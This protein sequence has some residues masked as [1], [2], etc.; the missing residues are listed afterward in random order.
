MRATVTD[1]GRLIAVFDDMER[2]IEGRLTAFT[3]NLTP[4]KPQSTVERIL[5]PERRRALSLLSA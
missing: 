3:M 1:Q 4:S 5:N 2:G